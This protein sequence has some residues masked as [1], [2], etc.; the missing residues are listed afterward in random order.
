[1]GTKYVA[2]IDIN[3]SVGQIRVTGYSPRLVG[4]EC[5]YR[6]EQQV[7]GELGLQNVL[8]WVIRG[9]RSNRDG[10]REIEF[11]F[12]RDEHVSKCLRIL[13]E[14]ER[15]QCE[16]VS[17]RDTEN[18]VSKIFNWYPENTV[19]YPCVV[20]YRMILNSTV[21]KKVTTL[22]NPWLEIGMT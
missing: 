13:T 16:Q 4:Y 15:E 18:W 6:L 21:G 3:D 7:W 8:S 22:D 5:V 11:R 12:R 17:Y 9:L 1:M 19:F 2:L 14:I 10:I 20:T